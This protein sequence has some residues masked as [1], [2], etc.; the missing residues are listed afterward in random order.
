MDLNGG[1]VISLDYELMWGVRDVQS[2]ETYG[3]N[4]LNVQEAFEKMLKLFEL[5]N[6][7]V[8]VATVGFL[9]HKNKSELLANLPKTTPDYLDQKCSPYPDM[10]EYLVN[11][12]DVAIYFNA[13]LTKKL[14]NHK[15]VEMASHTYSHFYC[16]ESI[17]GIDAFVE[18]TVYIKETAAANG[19]HL[20][21]IVFPRNQFTP[22]HIEVC[23][24]FGISAYRGNPNHWIYRPVPE[25]KQGIF[26][27]MFRLLDSYI[28]ITGHHCYSLS[29]IN[30]ETPYNIAASRFLRPYSHTLSVLEELKLARIKKSMTYAAKNKQIYHLW[31]HPHNF[32][33][34]LSENLDGL[35]TILQHYSMLHKKYGFTSVTMNDLSNQL[36]K[37]T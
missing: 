35:K 5:Y 28:N 20:K 37:T 29:N 36:T 7:K 6:T 24:Q 12:K 22:R 16:L 19:A 10:Q 15:N 32:G 21:S 2:E 26:R 11:C 27:R 18:D 33:A 3:E 23:A 30:T 17:G 4:I 13:P 1:F 25:N 34:N 14:V 31:W 8:T 9:F